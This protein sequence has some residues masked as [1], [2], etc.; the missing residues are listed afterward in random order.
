MA[1]CFC[2]CEILFGM[3]FIEICQSHKKST[4]KYGFEIEVMI[5]NIIVQK[6][7]GEISNKTRADLKNP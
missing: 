6:F 3:S 7:N 1:L 2:R 4:N 5:N